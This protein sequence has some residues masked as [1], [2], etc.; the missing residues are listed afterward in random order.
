MGILKNLS[1][2]SERIGA[3]T[4]DFGDIL[5]EK[6]REFSCTLWENYPDKIT[7]GEQV[8]GSFT[9]GFM[10]RMCR[11]K[12]L[13]SAPIPTQSPGKCPVPYIITAN[14]IVS[15]KN[16]FRGLDVGDTVLITPNNFSTLGPI[17]SLDVTP[18]V[19]DTNVKI[20]GL[21]EPSNNLNTYFYNGGQVKWSL[22]DGV[23][24][25][26]S[27]IFISEITEFFYARQDGLPDDCG[28]TE[29]V[30]PPSNPGVND[31]TTIININSEDGDTI[32]YPLTYNPI[33]ISFPMHFDLGGITIVIDLGGINF[34]FNLVNIDGVGIPLPGDILPPL[35]PPEDDK[36]R[37]IPVPKLPPPTNPIF[38]PLPRDETDPKEE[39]VGIELEF[40]RVTLISKPSNHKR[41]W[42]DG[43]PNVIYA[44]WF[45]FQSEGYNFKRNPIHFDN[46]L[47]RKP[48]GATGY[49]YTLYEGF[50]GFATVYIKKEEDT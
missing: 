19:P 29:Q 24:L 5:A 43:A 20:R 7:N 12:T 11:D 34:N 27:G 9:R 6:T 39:E 46:C 8:N 36:N 30:Y 41:Q 38:Q 4:A 40:V 45:E 32:S 26:I 13:P 16:A 25:A 33:N 50:T 31:Y 18:F 37:E 15:R 1:E 49:A 35:L 22:A 47:F 17:D 48:E 10:N 42:G 2:L 21:P 44:G 3:G 14:A 28:D 23:E